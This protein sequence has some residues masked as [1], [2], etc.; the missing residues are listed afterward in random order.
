MA[1]EIKTPKKGHLIVEAEPE[2]LRRIFG[3]D[4]PGSKN[5]YL[6]LTYIK[7]ISWSISNAVCLKLDI[8]RSKK[9]FELT[10]EEISKIESFLKE[11]PIADY[12]KNRRFDPET[13]EN[14]HYFGTDLDMKKEFDIKR[15]I[16]MRSYKGIRHASG[17]PVRGQKTRSHFRDR[18]NK[19][20]AG[21]KKKEKPAKEI[22]QK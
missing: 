11:L 2:I 4:I 5:I 8:P 19:K 1:E 7:G 17:Q 6:G 13:G 9:I 10:K 15:L 3:Y 14:K 12:L 20:T 21:I 22:K 16:R 18:K